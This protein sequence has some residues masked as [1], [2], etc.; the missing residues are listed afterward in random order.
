M[1]FKPSN[2]SEFNLSAK[3]LSNRR[4]EVANFK[5]LFSSESYLIEALFNSSD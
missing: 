1:F 3:I 4:D 5:V 2:Y